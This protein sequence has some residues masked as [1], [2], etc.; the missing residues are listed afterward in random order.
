MRTLLQEGGFQPH[1]FT[2]PEGEASK[3][4]QYFQ[5]IV[6]WLVE[7]RAER[8]EAIIALGG[9]V[10]GDLAGFIASCYLRGVPFVQVPTTLLGQVDSALGGK[11]GF[12][13]TLGKNLIGSYYHPKLIYVD[14]AFILTL[15][16]RIY[17]EGWVEIAKYAMILDGGLFTLLEEN[18]DALQVRDPA[19]LTSVV[20]RSI[21]M[22][23][24]I[25]QRDE[26]DFGLRNILNYGHTFG[27]ALEAITDYSTWLHGEAVAIGMEVAAHVAVASGKLSPDEAARQTKL[28]QALNLPIRCS[29]VDIDAILNTMQRDKKVRDGRMRWVLPTRIGHAE[30][31]SDIDTAIV[32]EAVMA[33]CQ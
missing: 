19:L 17:D 23:M 15:P 1:I 9:G 5:Q 18:F 2:I 3:S 7:H 12:N 28:L 6:D 11:T 10:V 8:K 21:R 16:E 24:D 22:K 27:H 13:H 26:L 25:V 30:V 4:F 29:S 14:P 32:R 31:F 20:A 33:V